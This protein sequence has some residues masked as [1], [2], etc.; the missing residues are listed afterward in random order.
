MPGQFPQR[1]ETP[2]HLHQGPGW[3]IHQGP[4]WDIGARPDFNAAAILSAE[5][6]L[7][8]F[9]G[10]RHQ[11]PEQFLRRI[12]AATASS[13]PLV[14]ALVARKQI[15]G[16]AADYI[17]PFLDFEMSFGYIK[18][19]LMDRYASREA[20]SELFHHLANVEQK[21]DEPVGLF[22]METYHIWKRL[23]GDSEDLD[24]VAMAIPKLRLNIQQSLVCHGVQSLSDLIS[25]ATLAE[26]FNSRRR[27]TYQGPSNPRQPPASYQASGSRRPYYQQRTTARG[28]PTNHE[29][30]P[31]QHQQGPSNDRRGPARQ[32]QP[33]TG[34]WSGNEARHN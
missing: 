31:S 25:K 8:T 24:F 23:H 9:T 28:P 17:Y 20:R 32:Q 34:Q 30:R 10:A 21:P 11:D 26:E 13:S 1:P 4:G 19:L 2:R 3:D 5:D 14:Q 12:E 16:A 18:K 22:I 6:F 15:R 7:P 33:P 27:Q 29:A